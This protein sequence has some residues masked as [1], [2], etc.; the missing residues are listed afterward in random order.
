MHATQPQGGACPAPTRR[1]DGKPETA[2]DRR[3]FDLRESEAAAEYYAENELDHDR[4]P[5]ADGFTAWCHRQASS[6]DGYVVT[7]AGLQALADT[8]EAP[9]TA[10]S[11]LRSAALYLE[12]HGWIQGAYYDST[13]ASFTP[14]ACMV[15]AIGMACYGFPVEAPAQH[16]DDPGFLD[17]EEAV[18]HLDRYLLVED[19]SQAYEFNDAQGRTVA[20][21]TD[22]LRKAAARPAEELIDALRVIDARNADMAALAQLLTPC[23]IWAETAD[24]PQQVEHIHYPHQPGALSDCPACQ[25]GCF[26]AE[27][28]ICARCSDGN[29]DGCA[30][31]SAD[32]GEA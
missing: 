30:F 16:F 7:D 11:V 26:C 19:G 9:G 15:G 23:G 21:V 5:T 2:I 12:R 17:F 18:L 14:A 22:Q 10:A 6:E 24:K 3:F 1:F 8:A 32:G 13:A 25:A 29:T 27:A 4:V 28:A 31:C 20:M